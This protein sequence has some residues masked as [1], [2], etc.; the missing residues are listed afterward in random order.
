MHLCSVFL[1]H[2]IFKVYVLLNSFSPVAEKIE[3]ILMLRISRSW[4]AEVVFPMFVRHL[5]VYL[6]QAGCY[7]QRLISMCL[8]SWKL[9]TSPPT[10]GPGE[11]VWWFQQ[12]CTTAT[13]T[14][15]TKKKF[16][17]R[18]G[19]SF[20]RDGHGAGEGERDVSTASQISRIDLGDQSNDICP[21][22]DFGHIAVNFQ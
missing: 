19:G 12:D 10:N 11:F 14:P 2:E 13:P 22:L 9:T 3:S 5:C 6:T 4:R 20:R 18:G 8:E 16:F 15:L 17:F 1:C 21:L 7:W